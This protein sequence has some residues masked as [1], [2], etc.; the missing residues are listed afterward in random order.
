MFGT[1]HPDEIDDILFA[2][3]LG[4]LA[5]VADGLPWVVPIAY[6]YDGRAIHACTSPGRKL[7]AL[8]EN[9]IVAFGVVDQTDRRR[10]RSVIV[11]GTCEEIADPTVRQ[12]TITLL[13]DVASPV[14]CSEDGIVLR[15]RPSS[16]SG[17]W[18][19]LEI[20]PPHTYERT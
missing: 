8:R 4:H 20:P 18:L 3:H 7:A 1:I 14:R 2:H 9:P 5:C 11:E 15:I 19:E 6:V 17:R 13:A 12:R 10:W 16:T